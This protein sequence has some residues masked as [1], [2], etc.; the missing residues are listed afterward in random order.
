MV[1][2]FFISFRFSL[3]F[4]YHPSLKMPQN[5]EKCIFVNISKTSQVVHIPPI[6]MF[7]IVKACEGTNLQQETTN[8]FSPKVL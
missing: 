6:K 5:F 3:H 1:N 8:I 2:V 7:P 4:L